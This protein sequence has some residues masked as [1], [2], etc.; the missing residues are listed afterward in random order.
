MD[1][2]LTVRNAILKVLLPAQREVGTLWHLNEISVAEEHMVTMTTQR[3]MAVLADRVDRDPDSGRTVIAA[4][5][6]GNIHDIGIRAIAYLI[7]IAGW[8]TIYLGPDVPKSDIP[9][10]V[11]CFDADLIMLSL[12]LSSQIPALQRAIDAIRKRNGSSVKIM[13]GGNGL[14]G[15]PDLWKDLGADGYAPTADAALAMA[16]ELVPVT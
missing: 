12:A 5:V 11:E 9:A 1:D 7:E 13:I 6:A 2:G 10:A 15:A 4:A 16:N 8:R 3:L 14:A